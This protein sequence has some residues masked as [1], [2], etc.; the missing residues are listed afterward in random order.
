MPAVRRPY[1]AGNAPDADAFRQDDAVQAI[2]HVVVIAADMKLAEGILDYIRRLHDHLIQQRVV[3]T[4][5]R[6]DRGVIDGVGRGAGLG[7][8]TGAFLI[9]LLGGDHDRRQ[10][11]VLGR[12][13]H[14]GIG[15]SGVSGASGPGG[16]QHWR[17]QHA[18]HRHG[19][20]ETGIRIRL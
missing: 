8:Y 14:G 3:A 2:L 7:L 15:V 4:G 10:R 17:G 5:C 19:Q 1:S 12:R 9:E 20:R 6:G 13:P 18:V 16:M 11:H